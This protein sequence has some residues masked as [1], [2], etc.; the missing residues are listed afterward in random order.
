MALE[1]F[2]VLLEN[3]LSVLDHYKEVLGKYIEASGV[4]SI[5]MAAFTSDDKAGA[6]IKDNVPQIVA[7]IQNMKRIGFGGA[8]FLENVIVRYIPGVP[9]FIISAMGKYLKLGAP[10]KKQND[11]YYFSKPPTADELKE[12][13]EMIA[14]EVLKQNH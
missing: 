5:V 9:V 3:D 6:F 11:C 10:G 4:H 1:Q 14:L 8:W 13:S 12:I 2:V 7:C